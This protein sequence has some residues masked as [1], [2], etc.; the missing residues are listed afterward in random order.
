M[1][2]PG[3]RNYRTDSNGVPITVAAIP[4]SD[5]NATGTGEPTIGNLVRDATTQV[6]ALVRAEVELAR[7]EVIRDVKKGVAGSIF[8]IAALVV[9]FYSTFFF[10][11]F[12]RRGAQDLAARLG[13]LSDHL[14]RHGVRRGAGGSHRLSASQA[15]PRTTG[16]HRERQGDGQRL[17]PRGRGTLEH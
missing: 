4:L 16:N 14:R 17:Q 6:S 9:L 15:H 1:S 13:G 7:A 3:S 11:F 5:P 2:S 8:F 12:R 10:F